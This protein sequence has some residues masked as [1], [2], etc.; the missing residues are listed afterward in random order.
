L[1]EVVPKSRISI[2]VKVNGPAGQRFIHPENLRNDYPK[3]TGGAP[4]WLWSYA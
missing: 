3:L 4:L 1:F 2:R